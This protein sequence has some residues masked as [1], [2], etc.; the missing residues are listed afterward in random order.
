M[1]SYFLLIMHDEY[2]WLLLLLYYILFSS[3]LLT[4]QNNPKLRR[5]NQCWSSWV[6]DQFMGPC[7]ERRLGQHRRER[8]VERGACFLQ[9]S[10]WFVPPQ[11]MGGIYTPEK[12]GDVHFVT[13]KHDMFMPLQLRGIYIYIHIS[14]SHLFWRNPVDLGDSQHCWSNAGCIPLNTPWIGSSHGSNSQVEIEPHVNQQLWN[15]H[16]L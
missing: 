4:Y 13:E 7:H 15:H 3:Y 12:A 11:K 1:A 16:Q 10:G 5:E 14:V 6:H 8:S 2:S 9:E